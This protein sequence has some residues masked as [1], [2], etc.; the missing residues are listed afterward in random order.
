[1]IKRILLATTFAALALPALAMAQAAPAPLGGVLA[2]NT[3]A[4]GTTGLSGLQ[5]QGGLSIN[6]QTDFVGGVQPGM[7]ES[8]SASV[9]TS[10]TATL[11]PVQSLANGLTV[12]TVGTTAGSQTSSLTDTNIAAGQ[13]AWTSNNVFGESTTNLGLYDGVTGLS[14]TS[15]SS[16]NSGDNNNG[17]GN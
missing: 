1:M 16:G 14:G 11:N 5:L 10:D 2:P 13:T 12:S 17:K 9:T 15:S 8:G 3:A 4:V 7:A 6:G